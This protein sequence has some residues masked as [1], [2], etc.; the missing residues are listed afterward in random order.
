M[1]SP[2]S[3]TPAGPLARADLANLFSDTDEKAPVQIY[4]DESSSNNLTAS[5]ET[6]N[7]QA[8]TQVASQPYVPGGSQSSELSEPED[9][10]DPDEENDPI[11]HSFGPFGANISSR[12]ATFT[13]RG[14]P[15]QPRGRTFRES[16][17]SPAKRSSSESTNDADPTPIVNHVVN[18]LA[19]S[20]LSST[21]LSVIMNHLPISLKG[22]SPTQVENRGLTKEDLHKIISAIPCIGEIHRE[23]KDAAGKPLESEYYY[24]PDEDH[25][26]Q[27]RAAVV[28]GLRKPSLRNCRKQHKVRLIMICESKQRG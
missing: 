11:I 23:G 18:Q 8:L 12:M 13:T 27:R 5:A 9:E 7:S 17:A 19:F 10:E 22:G 21:P 15:T 28:D 20:R 4:E 25:D 2:E 14:S 3:P 1:V 26:E 6:T 16:S 24:I